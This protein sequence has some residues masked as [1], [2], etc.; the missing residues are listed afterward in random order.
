MADAVLFVSDASQE[1]SGPELE[2]MRTARSL[3]PNVGCVMT[4]IDFYPAWRKILDLD[5][6]H[7]ANSGLE[8][9]LLPISSTLRQIATSSRD[10][11]IEEESGFAQLET[12]LGTEIVGQREQLVLRTAATEMMSV[13]AQ[14]ET[15][16]TSERNALADPDR[17]GNLVHQLEI[18]TEQ[19]D[20]LRSTAARW[21][22]TP[23]RRGRSSSRGCTARRPTTSSPTT[24]CCNGGRVRSRRALRSCSPRT[25]T[26]SPCNSTCRIPRSC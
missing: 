5:T 23:R 20:R 11:S 25:G 7:L 24:R 10:A 19:S 9:P 14:L 2:F 1:Y 22:T 6:A 26:T 4:K 8:A 13:I 21:P 18:A 12:Y 17:A 3:C 16:F 15:Q